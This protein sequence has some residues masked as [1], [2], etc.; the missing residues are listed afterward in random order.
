MTRMNAAPRLYVCGCV[1]VCLPCG[2]HCH[3]ELFLPHRPA[4]VFP[5]LRWFVRTSRLQSYILFN[6][7]SYIWKQHF[8]L[9]R[10]T[11]LWDYRCAICLNIIYFMSKIES[12]F[13]SVCDIQHRLYGWF[14][15][16]R[17]SLISLV[18]P[19]S[20]WVFYALIVRRQKSVYIIST[21]WVKRTLERV[22][23]CVCVHETF[24]ALKF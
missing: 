3:L 7:N 8:C 23:A 22:R 12:I 17:L 21:E 16:G 24:Q 6:V 18:F 20:L 11:C 5:H 19:L 9:C 2:R 13:T 1:C 10:L 14:W 4:A 15:M